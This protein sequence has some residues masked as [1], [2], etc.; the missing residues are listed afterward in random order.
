VSFFSVVPSKRYTF[1]LNPLFLRSLLLSFFPQPRGF[2]PPMLYQLF[3]SQTP[4]VQP[5]TAIF[6]QSRYVA[7]WPLPP[8]SYY[9]H[10]AVPPVNCARFLTMYYDS[11]FLS[12]PLPPTQLFFPSFSVWRSLSLHCNSLCTLA[13]HLFSRAF[14]SLVVTPFFSRMLTGVPFSSFVALPNDAASNFSRGQKPDFLYQV[15]CMSEHVPVR[16]T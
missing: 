2:S 5:I 15:F 6:I 3:F 9:F 8:P 12:T 7:L 4:F 16:R 1:P 11:S 10:Q 14:S 13:N